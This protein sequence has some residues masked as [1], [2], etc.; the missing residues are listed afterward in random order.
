VGNRGN[1]FS[2]QVREAGR[3]QWLEVLS[4]GQIEGAGRHE[5]KFGADVRSASS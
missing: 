5:L 3:D 1:Y 4:P 2:R